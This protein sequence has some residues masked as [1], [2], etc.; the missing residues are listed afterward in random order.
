[1]WGAGMKEEIFGGQ[2]G[3]FMLCVQSLVGQNRLPGVRV[4]W[5]QS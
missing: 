5:A 4:I 3:K 2:G 1:M